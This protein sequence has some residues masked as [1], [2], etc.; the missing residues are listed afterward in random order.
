MAQFTLSVRQRKTIGLLIEETLREQALVA[1]TTTVLAAN[2]VDRDACH[3]DMEQAMAEI[4][5]PTGGIR[6]VK[7]VFEPDGSW[8]GTITIT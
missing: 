3:A 6:N 2:K 1:Q 4:G 8:A 7:K 5:K